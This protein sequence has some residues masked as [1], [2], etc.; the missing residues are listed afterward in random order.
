MPKKVFFSR[1]IPYALS[2]FR[3]L[4]G[5]ASSSVE[6]TCFDSEEA[7]IPRD[8]LLRRVKGCDGLFCLLTDR[9]DKE[10]LAAAGPQLQVVSTMSVGYNHI[11]VAACHAQGVA[12]G[13]T[14]GV[15][16]VSTAETAVALTF[17]A[18]RRLVECVD[19]ARQGT[20]GVWQPFQYCGTDISGCTVGVIGLGRIGLTYARMMKF[21]F[22]CNI[23]YTGPQPKPA[24]EAALGGGVRYLP[25]NELLQQSDIVSVHLPLTDATRGIINTRCFSLMKPS[26]VLINTS[27]G[28]VVDQ[29][30]LVHALETREIAAAGLDV[31]TPEPLP[32]EHPLFT[33]PNCVILPH[34]GSA[35]VKTRQAMADIAVRNLVAGLT[36]EDL[37][38]PVHA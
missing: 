32:T 29:D 23:V 15:L 14:P 28:E 33:L 2:R 20:W 36:A 9:I 22:N 5:A 4:L 7:A 18:K 30:A 13:H 16:D 10:L 38:H 6:I 25:L 35:T 17:A 19:S 8:E 27:R 34:I 1:N 11:D 3:E 26:A 24:N 37:P 31:T 12:V 21:G